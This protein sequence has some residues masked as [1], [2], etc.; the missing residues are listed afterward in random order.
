MK[1]V[2]IFLFLFYT[3]GYVKGQKVEGYKFHAVYIPHNISKTI[4]IDGD[5]KEWNW[6]PNEYK[7]HNSDLIN[8]EQVTYDDLEIEFFVGWSK[9][10]NKIYIIC[11][12]IDDSLN[13]DQLYHDDG[14]DI[15]F[16]SNRISG[17]FTNENSYK[18]LFSNIFYASVSPT[19]TVNNMFITYGPRWIVINPEVFNF[20]VKI[21]RL[22][23]GKSLT[24]YE[25]ESKL[26]YDLSL[27][28][29]KL[30]S[31]FLLKSNQIIGLTIGFNDV[32]QNNFQRDI[33]LR[34]KSSDRSY[35]HIADEATWFILDPPR[36]LIDTYDEL[37]FYCS[38]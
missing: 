27:F 26:F 2:I 32:D 7:I 5:L 18:S 34:T 22:K 1:N 8:S 35:W 3:F 24:T 23:N 30:S 33:Q 25:I 28:S 19:S 10:N 36:D 17:Q 16:N 6:V 38:D 31:V 12:I 21:N 37:L 9:A 14:V 13:L 20:K 15:N 11:K 29:E 4:N